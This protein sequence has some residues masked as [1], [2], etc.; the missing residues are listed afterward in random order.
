MSFSVIFEE[1]LNKD[2]KQRKDLLPGGQ[3][4]PPSRTQSQA[5]HLHKKITSFAQKK[6][7]NCENSG[8]KMTLKP[9]ASFLLIKSECLSNCADE[10]LFQPSSL[11]NSVVA[12]RGM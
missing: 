12:E 1:F 7:F 6:R 3:I 4:W 11:R 5:S 9:S 8:K 10:D 2:V